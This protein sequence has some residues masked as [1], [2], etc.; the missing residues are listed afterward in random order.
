MD[1][2]ILV[3]APVGKDAR[4]VSQALERAGLTC[5]VCAHSQEIIG[6]LDKGAAGLLIVEEALTVEF[7]RA[8]TQYLKGQQA[9]SDLPMLVLAKRGLES[10]GMREVYQ[11]LGNV[12]LIER[13]VQTATLL[14]AANSTLRARKRQYEMREA[15]RRKD[16]FLAM[17]AHELRNPLAPVSAASELLRVADLDPQRIK[18]TS[19]I[20]SRQVRH[21]TALID[22]LLDVSRVSRGLVT[23]DKATLDA[24]LILK[25][26]VEQV[27]PLIDSRRHRLTVQTPPEAAY[28]QGDQKRLIQILANLIN[29]AAKYTPEGGDIIVTMDVTPEDV[30]YQV[31]DNGIGIAA[32]VIGHVFEMF[33]QA[34][35]TPD[36]SLGGL[37]IGLALVQ[38]LVDLHGGRV[39]AH[40]DGLGKGS[41]FSVTLPRVAQLDTPQ[42]ADAPEPASRQARRLRL[43]IV[44]DNVDAAEMLGLY[45]EAAGYEVLMEH[46]ATDALARAIQ[47]RPDVCL[48]DIGLPD[49]DG[50]Q[51]AQKIH[52]CPETN[53]A[54]LIA[55][56]GYGQE[57]DRKKTTAAGFKHHFVKPV[58][59]AMLLEAL[60][61]MPQITAKSAAVMTT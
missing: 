44:D 30:R 42:S 36:R 7:L 27:R 25:N 58:D 52:A 38:R 21:M 49:M 32:N 28:V 55:L 5:F 10:P 34:E 35:R 47:T 48:L 46:N 22:D 39:T 14:S 19:E 9:W 24:R 56:T 18:Q 15:D 12:T 20:I 11:Q 6:E 33:A 26:A 41:T 37:G 16:D 29:N 13:P 8:I 1:Y 57:Q 43:L 3:Y 45:L 4:L 40:S 31:V 59:M 17:L 61:G 23:L 54:L 2:R 51:L 50:N 53:E 60:E